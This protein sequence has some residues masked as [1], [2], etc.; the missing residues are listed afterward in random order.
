MAVGYE[1]G[2][3]ITIILQYN[4][5]CDAVATYFCYTNI[6]Y[7]MSHNKKLLPTE[8]LIGEFYETIKIIKIKS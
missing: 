8:M 1:I 5:I 2:N 7:E 6:N 3:R 4:Y